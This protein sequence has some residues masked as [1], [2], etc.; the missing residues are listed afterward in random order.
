MSQTAAALIFRRPNARRV[1]RCGWRLFAAYHRWVDDARRQRA[2]D[3]RVLDSPLVSFPGVQRL[4]CRRSRRSVFAD[5]CATRTYFQQATERDSA[6]LAPRQSLSL[7]LLYDGQPMAAITA[8]PG[9][10]HAGRCPGEG[11]GDWTASLVYPVELL[12]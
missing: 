5:V 7:Q 4:A 9:L 8:R 11:L 12:V 2:D 10:R 6:T 3:Y 1:A